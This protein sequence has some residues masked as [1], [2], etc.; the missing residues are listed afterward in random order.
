MIAETM[1]QSSYRGGGVR[2][3]AR[4]IDPT[5]FTRMFAENGTERNHT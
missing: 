1:T 3:S 2:L 4:R 5:G